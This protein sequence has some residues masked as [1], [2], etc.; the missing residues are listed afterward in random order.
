[1]YRAKGNPFE[2]LNRAGQVFEQKRAESFKKARSQG[3]AFALL[4]LGMVGHRQ[5]Y[6]TTAQILSQGP[7]Y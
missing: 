6:L 2:R 5:E 1:M 3:Q 7:F 4:A